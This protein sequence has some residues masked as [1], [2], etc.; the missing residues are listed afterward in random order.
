VIPAYQPQW[1]ARA[2]VKQVYESIKKY[3]L[4]LDEFEG[5]RYARLP[6]MKKLI[7]EEVVDERFN[8]IAKASRAA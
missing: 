5:A 1:S 4:T 7:A 6:H 8:Y 2:A 3:G